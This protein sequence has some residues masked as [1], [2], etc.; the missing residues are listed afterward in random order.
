MPY[1]TVRARCSPYGP[2]FKPTLAISPPCTRQLSI[3]Y[4][5]RLRLEWLRARSVCRCHLSRRAQRARERIDCRAVVLAASRPQRAILL[6]YAS[7]IFRRARQRPGCSPLSASHPLGKLVLARRARAHSPVQRHHQASARSASPRYARLQHGASRCATRALREGARATPGMGFIGLAQGARSE[8]SW[9]RPD[10]V[11]TAGESVLSSCVI[12]K[13]R[14]RTRMS[15][16]RSGYSNA[17]GLEPRLHVW[18]SRRPAIRCTR[19]TSHACF[20]SASAWSTLI[21]GSSSPTCSCRLWGVHYGPEN[22]SRAHAMALA[23][24]RARISEDLR[25]ET[26]GYSAHA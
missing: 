6:Q 22:Q 11:S 14:V 4:H 13:R 17:S 3:R 16:E 20:P 24:Q 2:A 23:Q 7:G 18:T 9:R 8:T 19:G 12:R 5:P 10:R 1:A 26:V 25:S 21:A 15:R